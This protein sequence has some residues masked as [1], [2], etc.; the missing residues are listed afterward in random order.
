MRA[1]EQNRLMTGDRL[2]R[3]SLRLDAIYC[4][5]LGILVGIAAPFATNPVGL[6][7]VLLVGTGIATALW[8]VYVWRASRAQP[9]RTSTR[10]VMIANIVASAGLAVTGLFAGT[11][12]LALA[13]GVLAI[14]IAAFAV[15]QGIALRRMQRASA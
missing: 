13:A 10:L 3:A 5:A 8:G 7:V 14:D 4:V 15:S 2:A 11:T 9:L 12:V 1:V 6:P